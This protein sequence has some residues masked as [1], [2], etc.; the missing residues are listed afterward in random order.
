MLQQERPQTPER[1]RSIRTFAAVRLLD[2][3]EPVRV[4]TAGERHQ[5]LDDPELVGMVDRPPQRGRRPGPS[6]RCP[7]SLRDLLLDASVTIPP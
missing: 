6:R 5:R 7:R 4:Q 3:T 1:R 2:R